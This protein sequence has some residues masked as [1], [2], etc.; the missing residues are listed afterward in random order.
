M[1][2]EAEDAVSTAV[3]L[4]RKL[5][6]RSQNTSTTR[7]AINEQLLD[8]SIKKNT[9]FI[10]KLKISLT[11]ENSSNLK[12]E[13]MT[14]KLEKYLS[15]IVAVIA[16]HKFG[17]PLDVWAAVELCSLLHQRFPDFA[18]LL[19]PSLIKVLPPP[20]ALSTIAAEV[21]ERE[22]QSRILRQKGIL[23][24]LTDLY[25]VGVFPTGKCPY[26]SDAVKNLIAADKEYQNVAI[27]AAFA[28]TFGD[29]FSAKD[30]D[31]EEPKE[32]AKLFPST[33]VNSINGTLSDYHTGVS[34]YLTRMHKHIQKMQ[35]S[36]QE[37]LFARGD[38]SDDR[39]EKLQ[40]AVKL[41]EKLN[42]HVK[43]LSEALALPMPDL[44]IENLND[45][46]TMNIN[47][48]VSNANEKASGSA[49]DIWEDEDS[50]AFYEDLVELRDFVPN[51]L[52]G[53]K[54]EIVESLNTFTIEDSGDPAEEESKTIDLVSESKDEE[55]EKIETNE[56]ASID[57]VSNRA[58]TVITKLLSALNRTAVDEVAVE[59]G[60]LNS[61]TARKKLISVLN[62]LPRGRNDVLPYISRFIAT[63]SPYM[64]DVA[65]SVMAETMRFIA[66]LTKFRVL[67]IH[68]PLFVLK[69]LIDDFSH[70]SIELICPFLES[71]GRF[72]FKSVESH[73]RTEALLEV[74]LRKKGVQNLDSYS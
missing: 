69:A 72:L 58:E 66:E 11:A 52:L 42:S 38:L 39:Q 30:S 31:N 16:D 61:K 62:S 44:V 33:V 63:V 49:L 37:L 64:P 41:F 10:R 36:N 1:E 70:L 18:E 56:S 23:R 57:S 48:G 19:G 5:E 28:K 43:V 2:K 51:V 25:I 7:A 9:A 60:F 50:R 22:E 27:A 26:L 3:T 17:K 67:P 73:A 65:A 74:L 24:L 53:E 20:P 32:S 6:L 45:K 35:Q 40:K 46:G 68:V 54:Q 13:L 8:G 55:D 4:T 59:F 12:K 15:E 47:Y 34:K 21:R 14:L 29:L 71:C